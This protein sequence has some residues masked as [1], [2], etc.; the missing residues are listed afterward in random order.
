MSWLWRV[1]RTIPQSQLPRLRPLTWTRS[2]SRIRA[3][4]PPPFPI[5][6]TCPS[7]TCACRPMPS[8]LD[9]D[10]EHSINGLMAPYAEQVLIS[11]GKDDWTSKIEEDEVSVMARGLKDL[12]GR[13]GKFSDPYHNVMIT[14][15]SFE[16]PHQLSSN[17]GSVFL[18]PSFR[19]L[20]DIPLKPEGLEQ[21]V[22]AFV[23]PTQLHQ[24]HSV[25]PEQQKQN[26]LRDTALQDQ[27]KG[28]RPVQEVLVLICGHGGRDSRCGTM[29]PLFRSEFEEKLTMQGFEVLQ[30]AVGSLG[31]GG[32]SEKPT[33]RVG[34]ISHIGG[35][36]FAGNVIIYVPPSF[37]ENP[38]A[39]SGIWYGRVRP[40]HVEGIVASTILQGKVIKELYRG[41]IA[42]EGKL[43][44]L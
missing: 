41:G 38:L 25:L 34:L 7:P 4:I 42:Q 26:L 1:P 6:E 10:V 24:M 27:F 8:G 19:Y 5:I 20:P 28:S 43:L 14:N 13:G 15:S 23:L 32:A 39:G 33:A 17:K 2:A 11:T 29:G 18:L 12:L 21:M 30:G 37:P 40:E 31:F 16:S 44:L 22:K 36:K 3:H 9:I 35:H